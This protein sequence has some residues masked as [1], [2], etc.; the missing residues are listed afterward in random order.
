VGQTSPKVGE[1]LR[2]SKILI[3]TKD[4]NYTVEIDYGNPLNPNDTTVGH[5]DMNSHDYTVEFVTSTHKTDWLLPIIIPLDNH[6]SDE[7]YKGPSAECIL[8][9]IIARVFITVLF[10]VKYIF[11]SDNPWMSFSY[12]QHFIFFFRI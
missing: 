10:L 9:C 12:E 8:L 1:V 11:G 5:L 2:V 6:G 3:I 4:N 7:S